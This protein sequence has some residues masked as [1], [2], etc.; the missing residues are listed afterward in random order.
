MTKLDIHC[1]CFTQDSDEVEHKSVTQKMSNNKKRH[2]NGVT[3][4]NVSQRVTS[5]WHVTQIDVT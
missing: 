4:K 1:T 3:Q 2:T 5:D